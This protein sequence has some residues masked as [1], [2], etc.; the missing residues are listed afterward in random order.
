MRRTAGVCHPACFFPAAAALLDLMAGINID[1]RFPRLIVTERF[2]GLFYLVATKKRRGHVRSAAAPLTFS[3]AARS[4]ET[5]AA[6]LRGNV[7]GFSRGSV[8]AE[9]LRD[10]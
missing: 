2:E 6:R 9:I 7:S 10:R 3:A 8:P 4:L 5:E 1:G